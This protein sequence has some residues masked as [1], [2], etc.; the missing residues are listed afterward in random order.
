MF[1]DFNRTEAFAVQV[2]CNAL[3]FVQKWEIH[4]LILKVVGE[5][6]MGC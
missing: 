6:D 3:L 2:K 1:H 4:F 5:D